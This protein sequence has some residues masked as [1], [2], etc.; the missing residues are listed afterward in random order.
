MIV[1]L[2]LLMCSVDGLILLRLVLREWKNPTFIAYV[3]VLLQIPFHGF[4]LP[5]YKDFSF[6]LFQ[7]GI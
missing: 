5:D 7:V 3:F 2:F 4:E 6:S 1:S